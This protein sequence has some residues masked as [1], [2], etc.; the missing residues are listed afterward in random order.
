M[1]FNGMVYSAD[2]IN[3]RLKEFYGADI[4]GRPHFRLVWSEDI[5]EKQYGEHYE[6]SEQG[7][8]LRTFIGT[9]E[10]PKYAYSGICDSYIVE[11]LTGTPNNDEIETSDFYEPIWSFGKELPT[12]RAVQFLV[13]SALHPKKKLGLSEQDLRDAS[14][15]QILEQL[16]GNSDGDHRFSQGSALLLPGK[17]F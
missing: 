2:S 15:K 16:F 11:R 1:T 4:Q 13:Y 10:V 5:K 3:Q 9:K 7:I 8:F 12:W 14:I 6:Y 17:D